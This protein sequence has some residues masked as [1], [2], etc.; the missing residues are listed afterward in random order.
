MLGASTDLKL[1]TVFLARRLARER[2]EVTTLAMAGLNVADSLMYSGD[3]SESRVVLG[4]IAWKPVWWLFQFYGTQING[5]PE[6]WNSAGVILGT[7]PP[8]VSVGWRRVAWAWC[9]IGSHI[10]SHDV[11]VWLAGPACLPTPRG[12]VGPV[13]VHPSGLEGSCGSGGIGLC[14]AT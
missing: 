2:D 5:I 12:C 13:G 14:A 8:D 10:G 1:R 9:R 11:W 6:N 4:S 7:V 3:F